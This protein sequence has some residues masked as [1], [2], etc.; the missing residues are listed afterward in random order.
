[1]LLLL[2][3]IALYC[4]TRV[5]ASCWVLSARLCS[6]A[7]PPPA[8]VSP[9][10][11]LDA[12]ASCW[13]TVRHKGQCQ[14]LEGL[15]PADEVVVDAVDGQAQELILLQCAEQPLKLTSVLL[16]V[17]SFDGANMHQHSNQLYGQQA[18]HSTG[19]PK[20]HNVWRC[21]VMSHLVHEY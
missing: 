15:V 2:L 3:C 6:A 20:E 5:P 16:F 19:W 18:N 7:G 1:L 12:P 17:S 10:A 13:L 4:C 21:A 11:A 14:A 8:A 9:P